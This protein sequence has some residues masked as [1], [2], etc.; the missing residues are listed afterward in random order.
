MKE[1][2]V[3][4]LVRGAAPSDTTPP[5]P[6][7]T[8]APSGNLNTGDMFGGLGGL[9]GMPGL[10]MGSIEQMMQN[11]AVVREMMNSPMMQNIMQNPEII[12]SMLANNPQM[13]EI[14]ERNPEVGHLLND[15]QVSSHD[16]PHIPHY[17][18]VSVRRAHL[19]G[20]SF[21]CALHAGKN[22]LL[23]PRA[24]LFMRFI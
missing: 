4:H 5:A 21:L 11:P 18:R 3:I 13:R 16:L 2:S 22:N 23:T 8:P 6:T 14:I 24:I 7:P 19:I 12:R 10:G 1:G 15:P 9:G 17:S 20:C